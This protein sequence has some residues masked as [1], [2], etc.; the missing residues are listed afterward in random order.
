M[1]RKPPNDSV[2]DLSVSPPDVV[3]VAD[4]VDCGD[5]EVVDELEE[6]EEV[7][8]VEGTEGYVSVGE[9]DARLQ[10]CWASFSSVVSSVGQVDSMQLNISPGKSG[11][12]QKQLTS[13]MLE[14]F[15]LAIP[16][17][18]QFVTQSE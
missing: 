8:V 12:T 5:D 3:A 6:E 17:A 9:A 2:P 7:E 18:K 14:Q 16:T 11:L 13:V 15:T 4:G 1:V 10:N